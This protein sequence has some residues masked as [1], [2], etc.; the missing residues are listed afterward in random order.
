V[1]RRLGITTVF[2]FDE[3]FREMGFDVVPEATA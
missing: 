3:H 1:M 2:A